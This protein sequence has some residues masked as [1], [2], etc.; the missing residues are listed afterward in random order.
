MTAIRES[1]NNTF[2]DHAV[3]GLPGSGDHDPQKAEIRATFA[4]IDVALGSLG[5]NGAITVKK[6]TLPELVADLAPG[7]GALAVV[8][9]DATPA[10]NGIYAKSGDSGVGSWDLTNL[11][12]PASFAADLAAVLA[13]IEQV[14]EDAAATAASAAA[15]AVDA[16]DAEGAKGAAEDARDQALAAAQ[17]TGPFVF[18]A[19]KAAAN[20]ALAGL[21]ANQLVQVWA[22]ESQGAAHTA[23]E[24]SGGVYV[25]RAVLSVSEARLAA[26]FGEPHPKMNLG[27]LSIQ[28]I[29]TNL[30]GISIPGDISPLYVSNTTSSADAGAFASGPNFPPGLAFLKYLG[31]PSAPT[32]ATSS[33]LQL[34]YLDF[35][36]FF[37]GEF[38]NA[39]S[40]DIV[41]DGAAVSTA[42]FP[43]PTKMRWAVSTGLIVYTAMEL[44]YDGTLELGANLGEDYFGPALVGGICK[45]FVN[46]RAN[47]Y[48][49]IFAARPEDGFSYGVR[50]HTAGATNGDLPI[51]VS[52]GAGG[53]SIRAVFTGAGR[54]GI[55][56][57]A[58]LF[59]IDV[60]GP[61]RCGQYTVATVPLASLGAGQEIYVSNESGGGVKAFSDGTSWRRCTDRAV[62][63]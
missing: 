1:A 50:F 42:G 39:A 13:Q 6:A 33:E 36:A 43:P 61:I 5:V 20:A 58:P 62:I 23:Y 12:L 46:Q 2:R 55:E 3:A 8:Y 4:V 45:L 32:D 37:G 19:T 54:L 57:S 52:S 15:A 18:Y 63:S 21:P 38:Y 27:D 51:V 48:T 17:L 10:N 47:E 22:D 14:A 56:T 40:F 31:T 35:R 29:A 44:K 24:K 25:L 49:A 53:G 34:G 16:A 26:A 11:A 28:V 59:P 60:A 41:I 30:N 7:D 9:N